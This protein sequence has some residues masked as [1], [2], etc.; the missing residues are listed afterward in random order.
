M[1]GAQEGENPVGHVGAGRVVDGLMAAERNSMA[2][3][4]ARFAQVADRAVRV[5]L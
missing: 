4:V 3:Y 2:H 1:I 5:S